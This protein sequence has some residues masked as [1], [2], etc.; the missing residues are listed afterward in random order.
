MSSLI[1]VDANPDSMYSIEKTTDIPSY[2]ISSI[3]GLSNIEGQ[4]FLI[5]NVF[6]SNNLYDKSNLMD[7]VAECLYEIDL[8]KI[9]DTMQLSRLAV[10]MLEEEE[11]LYASELCLVISTWN[12]V[13]ALRRLT[14]S[15]TLGLEFKGTYKVQDQKTVQLFSI[16][17]QDY[18]R[19]R[20]R[21]FTVFVFKMHRKVKP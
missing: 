5:E 12:Y 3:A 10:S 6:R 14:R 20:L 7:M 16:Q 21:R 15:P 13:D 17:E 18:Q 11:H 8:E 2:S 4:T 9:P 19:P 1:E